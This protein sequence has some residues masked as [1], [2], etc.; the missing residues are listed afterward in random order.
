MD[1]LLRNSETRGDGALRRPVL[2]T[3][4]FHFFNNINKINKHINRF[5]T[6]DEIFFSIYYTAIVYF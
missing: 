3:F 2:P 1:H 6:I 5:V 4:F